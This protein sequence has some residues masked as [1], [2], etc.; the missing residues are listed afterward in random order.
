[1]QLFKI[2][3]RLLALFLLL[4]V[5]TLLS[6]TLY[7]YYHQDQIIQ[8]FVAQTQHKL[9]TP[10][11]V[12]SV[13]LSLFKTFPRITIALQDVVIKDDTT[14]W[15]AAGNIGCAFNLWKLLRGQYVLDRLT[16]AQG[17]I[18]PAV[19]AGGVMKALEVKTTDPPPSAAP[20]PLALDLTKLILEDIDIVYSSQDEHY[21]LHAQYLQIGIRYAAAKLQA[22]LQGK[23]IIQRIQHPTIAWA[24]RLPL[25]LQAVLT[26]DQD[27]QEVTLKPVKIQKDNVQIALQGSWGLQKEAPGTIR[28]QG[29]C[30]TAK[31]L[32]AHLPERYQSDA[33]DGQFGFDFHMQKLTNQ[34]A[35][36][37]L[38]GTFAFQDVSYRTP[39]F[40]DPLK[41]KAAKGTLKIPDLKNLKTAQL[42]A[43]NIA[44]TLAQS[45]LIGSLTLSN[46]TQPKLQCTTQGKIDLAMFNP[47]LAQFPV[48]NVAGQLMLDCQVQ[49]NLI[50]F[51]R[52]VA[53][54]KDFSLNGTVRLQNL[55]AQ[56]K[57][58]AMSWK[59]LSAHL[60]FK[61]HNLTIKK[62]TGNLGPSRFALSANISQL[63]HALLK[64]DPSQLSIWGKLNMDDLDIDALKGKKSSTNPASSLLGIFFCKELDLDCDIKQIRRQHC[65][66][67]NMRGKVRLKGKKL[68][69]ENVQFVVA[70]GK[71]S[72]ES[73]LTARKKGLQL[74]ATA[75][76][77]GADLSQIFY[78][79]SNFQQTF[80]MDKHLRGQVSANCD[81]VLQADLQGN[82]RWDTMDA[83]IHTNLCSGV[84]L[85]FPPL[86]KLRP[87]LPQEK[88]REVYFP[89]LNTHLRIR[90]GTIHIPPTD[91]HTN[92]AE[93]Q[94]SGTHTLAGKINYDLMV[95]LKN[96]GGG[97]MA[98]FLAGTKAHLKMQGDVNNY[99]VTCEVQEAKQKLQETLTDVIDEHK[100]EI[101]EQLEKHQ[102]GKSLKKLAEDYLGF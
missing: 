61:D 75:K 79:F 73:V 47:L 100:E 101:K 102:D 58:S 39:H 46:L 38:N 76:V 49:A 83:D 50:P 69:T 31:A 28:I 14:T 26:Y 74:H 27:R 2:L 48:E 1:M 33:L 32:R 15:I 29:Q 30:I 56:G 78:T 40:T 96:F 34:K 80:L 92:L 36:I 35:P 62:F 19:L 23:A 16:I 17:Q 44:G 55:Q 97:I 45:Q 66:A 63:S 20:S 60:V 25:H 6:V 13:K 18:A 82:V 53:K 90:K 10:V 91:I 65:Q 24:P 12:R 68:T 42:E 67:K 70:K 99:Q 3:K 87:Y 43:H 22:N 93:M 9:K 72:L 51:M 11:E 95:P 5:G 71:V 88:L 7:C 84:L 94:F 77:Q 37:A 41:L 86:Q 52:K 64:K 59:G 81:L 54:P 89:T 98:D 57:D 85:D 21:A 4:V 8:K